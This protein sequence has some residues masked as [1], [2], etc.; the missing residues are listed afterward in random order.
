[1]LR[2]QRLTS[3]DPITLFAIVDE[4]VLH[5]MVA[6]P[7]VMQDQIRHLIAVAQLPNV[8]LQILSFDAGEH[9]FM[10]GPAALL[11]FPE[12]AQLD[13]IYLEGLAG[14]VYEEQPS[15]VARYRE[16][17]DRLSKKAHDHDSSVAVMKGLLD[18]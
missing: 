14:D 18:G 7:T 11:E 5:R 13:V 2:Q 9:P 10:G 17:F 16:E 12:I 8:T 4:S 15:E 1:L 6:G 3:A